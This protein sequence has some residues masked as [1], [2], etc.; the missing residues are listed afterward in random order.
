MFT[1][2]TKV[3]INSKTKRAYGVKI[4]RNN[5]PQV[6]RAKRDIILSAGALSSPQLLMLSG[7][8]KVFWIE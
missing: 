6:V 3:M 5:H 2:A 8:G 4:I 1:Q 7:V